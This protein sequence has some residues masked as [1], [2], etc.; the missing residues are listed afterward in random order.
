VTYQG[1]G[2]DVAETGSSGA[3]TTLMQQ[4]LFQTENADLLALWPELANLSLPYGGDNIGDPDSEIEEVL[5]QAQKYKAFPT[6][7]SAA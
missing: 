4:L 7:N 6:H 3:G 1:F 2:P 5:I